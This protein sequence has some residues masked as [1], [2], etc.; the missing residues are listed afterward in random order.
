MAT[1]ALFAH[2]LAFSSGSHSAFRFELTT[3]HYQRVYNINEITWKSLRSSS[4]LC[5]RLQVDARGGS[6]IMSGG[7][8]VDSGEE[9]LNINA[10]LKLESKF[11]HV[12]SWSSDEWWTTWTGDWMLFRVGPS[13]F[14]ACMHLS[15]SSLALLVYLTSFPWWNDPYL[16]VLPLC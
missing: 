2:L 3:L 9:G 15:P 14:H 8:K 16:P 7:H 12:N 4:W 13:S 10:L 5:E 11:N 6:F 1:I